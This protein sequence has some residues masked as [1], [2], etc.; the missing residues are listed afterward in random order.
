MLRD[1]D[2]ELELLLGDLL[3][4]RPLLI[5]R[6]FRD[7]GG[8]YGNDDGPELVLI[9]L[10]DDLLAAE[11]DD[12]EELELDEL[13]LLELELELQLLLEGLGLRALLNAFSSSFD[14]LRKL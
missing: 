2:L 14:R 6:L 9:V 7:R 10:L 11:D 13:E 1:L 5:Y 8:V 12:D 3:A 4:L